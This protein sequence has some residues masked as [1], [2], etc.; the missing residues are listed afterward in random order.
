[1]FHA[2]DDDLLN[3]GGFT[4]EDWIAIQKLEED[5]TFI[6]TGSISNIFDTLQ[7][8]LTI[9]ATKGLPSRQPLLTDELIYLTIGSV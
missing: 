4:K 7:Y 3:K 9:R 6:L 1:L 2:I 5:C 8:L